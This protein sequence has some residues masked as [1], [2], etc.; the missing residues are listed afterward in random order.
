MRASGRS[1]L[2]QFTHLLI[3]KLYYFLQYFVG[4]SDTLCQKH[5]YFQ[6][7]DYTVQCIHI[8]SMQFPL[9]TYGM[10][11]K[12]QYVDKTLTLR[13]SIFY[14]RVSGASELRKCVHFHILKLLF[15]IF[16][17]YFRYF[18]GTNDIL[19]GYACLIF[20]QTHGVALY[21]WVPWYGVGNDSCVNITLSVKRNITSSGRRS[22]KSTLSKLIIFGHNKL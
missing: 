6:V 17:W 5:V 1:E 10:A 9:I 21:L 7:S 20:Q 3:L 11:H 14:M 4:T 13:K 12:R 8:Q 18:V 2:R 22:L 15:S 19:V 16:C